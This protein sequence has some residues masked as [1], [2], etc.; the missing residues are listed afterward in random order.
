MKRIIGKKVKGFEFEPYKYGALNFAPSMRNYIGQI[1]IVASLND[2]GY[3]V[4]F[5]DGGSF[6]YPAEEIEKHLVEEKVEKT[7]PVTRKQLSEIYG[8]VCD[9]WKNEINTIIDNGGRFSESFEVPQS[10]IWKARSEA[11]TEQYQWIESVF[12]EVKKEL[13]VGKWYRLK[14]NNLV[15]TTSGLLKGHVSGYG[16]SHGGTKWSDEYPDFLVESFKEATPQEVEKALIE[17][18]K[19]RGLVNGVNIKSSWLQYGKTSDGKLGGRYNYIEKYNELEID[20]NVCLYTIFQNGQWAT[21]IEKDKIEVG[22]W[23]YLEEHG[24]K[25]V[26]EESQA[27]AL[28]NKGWSKVTDKQVLE[29]LNNYKTD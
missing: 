22:D 2:F 10:L 8:S 29:V 5:K 21:V 11:N 6:T 4:V 23:A 17:E 14:N 18:A 26:R 9:K 27:K 28:S 19:R 1:G 25:K 24:F 13:E 12:G 16:F 7:Y 20:S 3:T 15:F